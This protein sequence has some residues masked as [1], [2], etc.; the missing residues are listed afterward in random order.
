MA[1]RVSSIFIYP[2]KS[3]RGISL[4][5]APITATGFRWDRQ[6]V[7]VNAKGRACTQRVEPRLA[8]VVVE[9]PSE[10]FIEGWEPTESSYMVLKAPGMNVLKVSLSKPHGTADGVSV[11]EW[12]GSALDEGDEASQWF[13]DFLGKPCRLVRFNTASETRPVEP[14]YA[15]GHKVLFSDMYPYMLLSQGSLD[16]LN[17][18]L[19][20]PIPINRFRPNILVDGCEPFAEDLWTEIRINN[21]TFQGVKLCS[22]CKVPTINQETGIAG[23]EVSE[24]LKAFR[25]DTVLRPTQKRKGKVYFGQNLVWKDS[26]TVAEGKGK[27]I[28]VGDPVYVLRKVSSANEAAA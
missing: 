2:I 14:E 5:R 18:L 24:A 6:W 26:L 13:S 25:S 4:L 1:A 9:L 11:W 28:K 22:R 16:A 21:F 15:P 8:L 12:S 19:N 10:A 20:N 27:V 7:V 3:C 17:E 23:P